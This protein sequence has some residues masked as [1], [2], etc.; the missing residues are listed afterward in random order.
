[1]AHINTSRFS[2]G[3]LLLTSAIAAVGVSLGV[4]IRNAQAE[5]LDSRVM[6]RHLTAKTVIRGPK[7]VHPSTVT[8][9]KIAE[10]ALSDKAVAEQLFSD[11][12]AVAKQYNLSKLEIVVLH[13]MTREQLDTARQ[14]AA[15]LVASRQKLPKSE[16]IP[17]S[18]LDTKLITEGMFVGRSILAAAGRSYLDSAQAHAC[19]PWGPTIELGISADPSFYDS[20][21]K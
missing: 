14:D 18:A 15:A 3:L 21:F 16:K 12:D 10:L 1:M 4:P 7:S 19:C 9:L 5:S 20:A 17:A 8:L 11:P 6:P 2:K 13:Y